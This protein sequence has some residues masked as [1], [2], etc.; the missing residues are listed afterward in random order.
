MVNNCSILINSCDAYSDV[1]EPFFCTFYEYWENC[2]YPIFLNTETKNYSYGSLNI[3]S[4]NVL[5]KKSIPWGQRLLD[6]L[7]RIESKHVISLFDDF[8]LNDYVN[9]DKLIDYMNILE[10]NENINCIYLVDAFSDLIKDSE[11][12]E[13]PIGKDFRLNSAPALWRKDKLI[14]YTGKIDTP[15]AWEYFGTMRTEKKNTIFLSLGIQKDIYPYNYKLGG[16]IHGGKWVGSVINPVIEKYKL[17]LDVSV[18]GYE[19][20]YKKNYNHSFGWNLKF[21][22]IGF[23]MVGFKAFRFWHRVNVTIL[24]CAINKINR[25]LKCQK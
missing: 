7:N 22:N 8:I 1:W 20:E 3:V 10:N 4:L 25:I 23:K 15:W 14:E 18:R 17:N 13:I 12:V 5:C 6:C 21:F 9:Q 19:D 2:K 11:F 16:A 24:K